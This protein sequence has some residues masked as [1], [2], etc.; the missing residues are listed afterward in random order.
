MHHQSD[1][2][3]KLATALSLAQADL[4]P[5]AK[6]STNPHFRSKY[7]DLQSIW[8]AA[9]PVLSKNNLS[10]VQTF[11][12]TDG[13]KMSI[14]TTLLHSSGEW[15]RGTLTMNPTKADPQGIGSAITY[16]RRYALAA[17]LGIVAD[18]DDDGNGASQPQTQA[19]T[20]PAATKTSTADPKPANAKETAKAPLGKITKASKDILAA[21]RKTEA[22][23]KATITLLSSWKLVDFD[24]ITEEEAHQAIAWIQAQVKGAK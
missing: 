2:I 21:F 1:S 17:I 14:V 12:E 8:N 5:A 15:M 7:A 20:A 22:G 19:R 11:N 18:E 9:R 10:V 16:G 13:T 6:D 23:E 4:S 24:E 3:G